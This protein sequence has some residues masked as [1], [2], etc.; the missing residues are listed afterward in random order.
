[1]ILDRIQKENDI[2]N[3]TEE[4]IS[5]LSEEIR[6]FLI[7]SISVFIAIRYYLQ[8][9]VINKNIF[10]MYNFISHKP[11]IFTLYQYI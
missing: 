7:E 11:Y 3:L 2:K 8:L 5:Q 1:M 10:S 4:E 6:Q 9:F